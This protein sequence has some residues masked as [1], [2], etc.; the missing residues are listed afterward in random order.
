MD[1]E[2]RSNRDG[3]QFSYN[4]AYDGGGA[5]YAYESTFSWNGGGTK[6]SYN[7]G[8]HHY[9]VGGAIAAYSSSVSWDG[10]GTE[11]VFNSASDGGAI[12]VDGG[13]RLHWNG[14]GLLFRNN[15]GGMGGS[16]YS[17]D[18]SVSWDGDGTQFVSCLGSAE[19]GAIMAFG[20]DLFWDG[21]TQFINNSAYFGDGG[22]M[23]LTLSST[24]SWTGGG[25]HFSSNTAGGSGGAIYVRETRLWY[26]G[27]T[28]T[29]FSN[30]IAG[31][32]GGALAFSYPINEFSSTALSYSYYF[33][34]QPS[35]DIS[36]VGG[37]FIGNEA[38]FD[39]GAIY[40]IEG[41][42]TDFENVTFQS[43][44]AG[45]DGAVAAHGDG[46][47]SFVGCNFL[48][49]TVTDTGGA[50]ETIYGYEWF[51]SSLFEGNSAGG[52]RH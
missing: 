46:Y 43:N 29:T 33:E 52:R 27:N 23:A 28:S 50:V 17:R 39:G 7:S 30:N 51:E 45:A 25:T 37:S 12:N 6:F 10:D 1:L 42:T 44:S 9:G 20:T 31:G 18:S 14:D 49:N 24:V 15:S 32:N 3:T 2:V 4:W 47:R 11:F 41:G 38:G 48:G 40:M 8:H 26:D 21:H 36:M 13:S 5:V 22:A 19:A 34:D 35:F 16:I